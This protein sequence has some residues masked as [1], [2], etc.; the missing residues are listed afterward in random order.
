M[1]SLDKGGKEK[2]GWVWG[3]RAP[4]GFINKCEWE[5]KLWARAKV[6][7]WSEIVKLSEIAESC[8]S[9]YSYVTSVGEIGKQSWVPEWAQ[10]H[11]LPQ[12]RS[13]CK[14]TILLF[15]TGSEGF[16]CKENPQGGAPVQA[17][18]YV[19][20]HLAQ[21]TSLTTGQTSAGPGRERWS[22]SH[23]PTVCGR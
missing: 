5:F 1:S 10:I 8:Q 15:H 12:Y 22:E 19:C 20:T 2:R 14:T 7:Q 17:Q 13:D 4:R 16:W 18:H 6:K 9:G 21:R 23:S 11:S 3:W